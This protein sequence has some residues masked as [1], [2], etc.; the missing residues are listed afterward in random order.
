MRAYSRLHATCRRAGRCGGS[1][2]SPPASLSK[3]GQADTAG[4]HHATDDP[5]E[6]DSL[7]TDTGL[8]QRILTNPAV[9]LFVALTVIAL[10][11]ERSLLG[12][13]PLGGGA[14]RARLGR[15]VRPVARVPA[16][17]PPGRASAPATARPP[18]LAVV[19]ALATVLGGKP[20]LAVDVI[21]LGCV[22]LAGM[23]GA[24]WRARVTR[25][26][27][28]RVWAA[29]GV[30]AAAGGHGR[31]RRGPVRHRG[32]LRAAAADRRCWPASMLTQPPRGPRRAAWA[33]GLLVA[34]AAAF[35]PLVW[36]IA[37]VAGAL[38][39]LVFRRQAPAVLRNLAIVALVPPVLLLPWT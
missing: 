36:V 21:L 39:A 32:G 13:G 18:Y 11:A 14:L 8:A 10:V 22:P 25:S 4:S 35:V 5:D 19:A 17:L 15:R 2:S 34:V 9:L 27:P 26:A 28:V 24:T 31:G 37:V 33:T 6:D 16:G 38:A 1:P 12:S 20:W 23:S 30:R 7:L 29:V 3:S